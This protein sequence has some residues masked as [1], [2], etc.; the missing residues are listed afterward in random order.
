MQHVKLGILGAGAAARRIHLPGLRL[1]PD[2]EVAAICDPD[3]GAAESSGIPDVYT[4]YQDLLARQDL[5]A[6][7][8]AAPNH[9]H[10]ELALAVIAAGK[11][12]LCEKPLALNFAEATAMRMAAEAAGIVHMTA[13][14][15][16]YC[17]AFRYLDHL[18][19]TGALGEIRSVR[20][21]Y[22]MAM[23]QHLHGWRSSRLLAG[24]GVLADVGSHLIH[25]A[26]TAA[27][28]IVSLTA[29]Q[30]RFRDDPSSDVED[31]VGFLARFAGGAC[32]TFE[33]SR[34]CPGRGAGMWE[35]IHLEVYGTEGSA[36]F[37]SRDTR[38]LQVAL[39][40]DARDPGR[41]LERIEAPREFWKLP[42][43]P[44]DEN[45]GDPLWD[46]RYDQAFQFVA[47]V[48]SGRPAAPTFADGASCQAV[49]DAV[50]RSA[51]TGGWVGVEA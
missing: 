13:F 51:E 14:T 17:P 10:R 30:R 22:L 23:A 37:W 49:L 39:G 41:L 20:A 43:A 50:L 34:V 15:Y 48:R 1:C 11:H 8:V 40:A 5:D 46:Y 33:I 4:R 47:N 25:L 28:P 36:V 42:G 44:R 32:G 19:S 29:H 26:L 27:G 24:S 9:L 18:V 16:R 7:I 45:A 12:V 31:W 2:V 38:A 21:A 35:N 6:V 3:R